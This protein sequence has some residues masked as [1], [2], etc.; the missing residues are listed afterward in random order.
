MNINNFAK[1]N[2]DNNCLMVFEMISGLVCKEPI[3]KDVFESY[4]NIKFE[5]RTYMSVS[6]YHTYL[7]RTFG[8]YMKLPP[9]NKRVTTHSFDPYWK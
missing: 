5:N 1:I 2:N 4:R 3:P 6:D 7:T 8:D 9:E